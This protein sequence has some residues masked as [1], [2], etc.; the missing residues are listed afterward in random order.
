MKPC[1]IC[2]KMVPASIRRRAIASFATIVG[3]MRRRFSYLG[4]RR[5][6]GG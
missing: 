2:V 5:D 1:R 6:R 3:K 4:L